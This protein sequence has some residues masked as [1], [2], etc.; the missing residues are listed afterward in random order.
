MATTIDRSDI[1]TN[2]D[3]SATTGTII[4]QAYI[5]LAIYDKIDA[6]LANDITLGGSLAVPAG[7]R[8]VA[9]GATIG[10]GGQVEAVGTDG[11]IVTVSSGTPTSCEGFFASFMKMADNVIYKMGVFAVSVTDA[12]V[13][14][15]YGSANIHSSYMV[16]GVQADD[17]WLC[18][19]GNHGAAFFPPDILSSSAPGQG[20]LR[21]T[22]RI[23][24]RKNTIGTT[25]TTDGL[26]LHN[27]TDAALGAQQY[28][29]RLRMGGRGW[30][31]AGSASHEVDFAW[32][33]RP[34]QGSAAPTGNLLL[35]F[36]VDDAGYSEVA[37]FNSSGNLSLIG[38]LEVGT[39]T[40]S[41]G[42]LRLPNATQIKARN[43]AN[44]ADKTLLY[45][46]GS[47][48]VRID[49][50]ACGT[51][52]G[53]TVTVEGDFLSIGTSPSTTGAIRI[54][55]ATHIKA[56]NAANNADKLLLYLSGSDK[57][58][59]DNDACGT[60]I[61]GQLT[62]EVIGAFSG[63]DK[64]LVVDASGNVHVSALGPAS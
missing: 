16:A 36:A 10:S 59:I 11:G 8:L 2:D 26:T 20:I 44:N 56:R 47:D 24:V 31:T 40:A 12:T 5:A 43:A 49:N 48:K 46:S 6:I 57:V 62:L 53:G 37:T 58:R 19:W 45:L 54:P 25:T 28:S 41:S 50:D 21:V 51:Q 34:S 18:G 42:G 55:N 35:T 33:V 3:G 60:M 17:I 14:N 38:A 52:L 15:G 30:A 27:I 4:N 63:G 7:E 9:G 64:Y 32:Q 29:P 22:G 1:G 39:N 23:Q 61:A 13:S